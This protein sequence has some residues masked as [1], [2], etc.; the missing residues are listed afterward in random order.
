MSESLYK[1]ISKNYSHNAIKREINYRTRQ[2]IKKELKNR[3]V[4][5]DRII[6]V[7]K[8]EALNKT[9]YEEKDIIIKHRF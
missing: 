8:P 5:K 2:L 4:E 9:T 7:L 6:I 1:I 3:L